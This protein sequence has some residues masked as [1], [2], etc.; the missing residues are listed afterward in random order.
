MNRTDRIFSRFPEET[1]KP[2]SAWR[3]KIG[4]YICRARAYRAG[5]IKAYTTPLTISAKRIVYFRFHP[6][7]GNEKNPNKAVNHVY[8]KKLKSNPFIFIH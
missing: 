4:Q 3:Q 8:S 6:E 1:V 7:T 5:K 2:A